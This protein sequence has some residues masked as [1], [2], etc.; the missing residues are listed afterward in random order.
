MNTTHIH[1]IVE[2]VQNLLEKLGFSASVFVSV[3]DEEKDTFICKVQVE[4]DQHFL[5]G[6]YGT[7][8]S[9]LQHLVRVIL[10]KKIDCPFHIIVDV[11][12]YFF[13]KKVLLE[14]EAE[15]AMNEV[16]KNT[17]SV[18]LRPM[19]SYER[20]VIH[21][22]LAKYGTVRTESIGHG[23]E[24]R[25]RVSLCDDEERENSEEKAE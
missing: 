20:K 14:R 5:I 15:K 22:F 3:S 12:D 8:L 21:S 24:R 11:N 18:S 19:L 17:L 25:V 1:I 13:E 6:Q 4:K 2:T 9:A 7:N 16:L 23:N 10:H